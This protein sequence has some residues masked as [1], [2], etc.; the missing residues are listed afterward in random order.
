MPE[1]KL[2]VASMFLQS[3]K[4]TL[5]HLMQQSTPVQSIVK[6]EVSELSESHGHALPHL[7]ERVYCM[8]NSSLRN[9]IMQELRRPFSP[10]SLTAHEEQQMIVHRIR[11]INWHLRL[12]SRDT[13]LD[14]REYS[15]NQYRSILLELER[16]SLQLLL[17]DMGI[18]DC[19]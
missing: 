1:S 9:M 8:G 5:Q 10:Q 16:T 12:L 7:C 11:T 14:Q 13:V 2:T 6:Q 18:M 15:R 3:Q 17:E 4:D 19:S